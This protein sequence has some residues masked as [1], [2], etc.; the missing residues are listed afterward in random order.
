MY[1]IYLADQRLKK[2]NKRK[3]LIL[4]D[5]IEKIKVI[6]KWTLLSFRWW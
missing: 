4:S 5:S 2:G 6:I 1:S 3:L